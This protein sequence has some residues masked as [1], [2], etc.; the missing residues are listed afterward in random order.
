MA[1]VK[2]AALQ[3]IVVSLVN[4]AVMSVVIPSALQDVHLTAMTGECLMVLMQV[5]QLATSRAS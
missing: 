5:I 1:L 4:H 2:D 3:V